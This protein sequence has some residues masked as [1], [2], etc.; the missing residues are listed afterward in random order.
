M[1]FIPQGQSLLQ[2]TEHWIPS[3]PL[4]CD[5]EQ[6]HRLHEPN[7]L[8]NSIDP[9]S[10][11][12]IIDRGSHPHLDDGNLTIYFES[13]ETRKTCLNTPIDPPFAKLP[14]KGSIEDDRGG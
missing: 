8:N 1:E 14:S 5:Q 13:E 6:S 7:H 2:G 10:G 11:R 9:I 12:D 4:P 3:E